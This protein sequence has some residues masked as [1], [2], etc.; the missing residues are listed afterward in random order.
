MKNS[1]HIKVY[2]AKA[3]GFNSTQLLNEYKCQ[4]PNNSGIWNDF[5]IGTDNIDE[6]DILIIQDVCTDEEFLKFDKTKRY[7][8][9]REALDRIS[10]KKYKDLGIIDCSF[11]NNNNNSY[12]WTKWLYKKKINGPS[13]GINK[14]YNELIELKP[15]IKKKKV[16]CILSNKKDCGG[17]KLRVEFMDEFRKYYDI[18]IYGDVSYANK[19]LVNNEKFPSLIDYEYCI[20]FDNQDDIEKFFGTQ[21]TDSILCYTIPIYWGG[22]NNILHSY[23]PNKSFETFDVRNFKSI[24]KIINIL[25]KTNYNDRLNDIVIARKLILNRYNVW[26][27]I[28]ME[29]KKHYF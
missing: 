22:S 13:P 2:F 4:S 24:Q 5:I 16:C 20:A 14:T 27:T 28:E 19:T 21:F 18:D 8:F 9:S 29:V 17:H 12:L 15:P 26:P 11:W 3:W 23:F 25:E 10:Y 6:A 1:K 7:Y